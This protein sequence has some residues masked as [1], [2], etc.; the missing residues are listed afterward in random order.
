MFWIYCHPDPITNVLQKEMFL[1]ILPQY[2]MS[3][4][5]CLFVLSLKNYISKYERQLFAG[6][7]DEKE[8]SQEDL[9][10]ELI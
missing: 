7:R 10:M 8:F 5:K 2:I 6:Y 1:T 9:T 3:G 4:F